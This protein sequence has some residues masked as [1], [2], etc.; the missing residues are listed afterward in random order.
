MTTATSSI[1]KNSFS[2]FKPASS[3][4]RIRSSFELSREIKDEQRQPGLSVE[5]PRCLDHV[6]SVT[7]R[8]K[9]L[10]AVPAP[11]VPAQRSLHLA[12]RCQ[13]RVNTSPTFEPRRARGAETGSNASLGE[14]PIRSESPSEEGGKGAVQFRRRPPP[15][16]PSVTG[17]WWLVPRPCPRRSPNLVLSPLGSVLFLAFFPE[18]IWSECLHLSPGPRQP[19][20]PVR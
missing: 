16:P 4:P 15:P 1:P 12:P 20:N 19:G 8:R 3:D 14:R 2:L 10:Q 5:R 9:G 18:W 11:G 13:D 6:D 17:S 7:G